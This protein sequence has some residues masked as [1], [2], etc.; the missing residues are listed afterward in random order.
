[1]TA[2]SIEPTTLLVHEGT[3]RSNLDGFTDH[4]HHTPF[5]MFGFIKLFLRQLNM[6]KLVMP[7]LIRHPVS[8]VDSGFRRNDGIL[9]IMLPE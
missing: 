6:S 2:A 7:D 4:W 3:F 5:F 1:M 8:S 9:D